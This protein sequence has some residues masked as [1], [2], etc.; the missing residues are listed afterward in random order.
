MRIIVQVNI[1]TLKDFMYKSGKLYIP[2][3]EKIIPNLNVM[4]E[5]GKKMEFKVVNIADYHTKF[6]AEINDEKPDWKNTFPSHCIIGTEGGEFIN[7]TYPKCLH[8]NYY[9]LDYC[10]N[11]ELNY[12]L[13]N[14]SRNIVVY[15]DAFNV[16]EGNLNTYKLFD[17]LDA[18]LYVV[19]G[20]AT[21]IC[22]KFFVEELIKLDLA[23]VVV[24]DAVCGLD[25]FESK[26]L[27][28]K[29]VTIK[30]EEYEV[31]INNYIINGGT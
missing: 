15:K 6:S 5:I 7:E 2:N 19:Y 14:R 8:D 1:D 22:V 13:I 17:Y 31:F 18:H 30:T 25:E 21:D 11:S 4:T 3:S 12:A 20:V 23:Y 29:W 24:E 9:I 27:L 10:R 16:F 26:K 28:E